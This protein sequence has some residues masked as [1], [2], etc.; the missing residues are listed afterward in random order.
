MIEPLQQIVASAN[1]GAESTG[2]GAVGV[3]S[4]VG[5]IGTGILDTAATLVV[6]AVAIVALTLVGAFL[7]FYFVRDGAALWH[8]FTERIAADR[9]D[10]LDAAGGRAAGVLGGY[11]VGTGAISLFG[12]ATQFLIMA[13]LGIPLALPL[14][15]LSFFGGFIPY[16]GSLITTFL[17]FLVTVATGDQ[18]DIVVMAIFTLVFNIVTGNFVAPLV[19]GRAVSLHPAIVLVAIPVGSDLGGIVGMFLAVP[20]AGVVATT[21]RSILQ[22][23]DLDGPLAATPRPPRPDCRSGP[24]ARRAACVRAET[25]AIRLRP[26]SRQARWSSLTVCPLIPII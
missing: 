17:A 16:V 22:V 12:A 24:A 6:Q 9:R 15:V 20:I 11:M 3:T 18:T 21:W 7:T 5:A 25:R 10:V 23:L 4:F 13:I 2:T 1:A 19:Y 8:M 26:R 14:A